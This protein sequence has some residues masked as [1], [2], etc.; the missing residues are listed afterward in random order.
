MTSQISHRDT[1]VEGGGFPLALIPNQVLLDQATGRPGAAAASRLPTPWPDAPAHRR[2]SRRAS[3]RPHALAQPQRLDYHSVHNKIAREPMARSLL[4]SGLAGALLTLA[5]AALAADIP[6]ACTSTT[7]AVTGGPLPPP[8]SD[9]VVIRWLGNANFEFA[10]K[11]KVFLFDAY[12]D[13]TPRSHK[14]G[15]TAADVKKAEA[16]LV[17]HAHFDH[18][19]DIGAVARQTGA[20]VVGAP[21]TIETAK[22]LGAP[23][24]QLVV[25][26]G[27]ESMK[28]GDAT[29]EI[30]LA[31]HS[32][33]QP[34]LIDIYAS[35]YANDSPAFSDAEKNELARVRALGTFDPKVITEGT[36]AYALV[37]PSGFKAVLIGSAGPITPGVRALAEKLGPVDVAIVAYQVHAVADTQI[38][39]TWPFIALFKPKLFLPAH[40]DAAP[41]AWVDLGLEPLFDKIRAEMP[42]TAFLAP[43][44]RS[45]ICIAGAGPDKGKVV[46]FKY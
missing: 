35:L 11:G 36:L 17:S 21:I 1:T 23:E 29:V 42:G 4:V 19:S 22:T 7:A 43:L 45:P 24:R 12:F 3:A 37:L 15:F 6:E 16:I 32:T 2:A 39:Y 8:E 18:I 9:M 31:Q 41:P 40:H 46:S 44:Y 30:A 26:K 27:G 25:A 34:G 10:H 38:D 33:I 13:R 20:P 14:I 28:F 5:G